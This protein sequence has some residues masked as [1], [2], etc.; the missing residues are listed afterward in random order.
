MDKFHIHY[1][2]SY[3]KKM[4]LCRQRLGKN[5][6]KDESVR[7]ELWSHS[8]TRSICITWRRI[9]NTNS[10]ASLQTYCVRNSGG[11]AQALGLNKSAR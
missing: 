10:P 5:E 8:V 3:I 9:R 7:M 6:Q 11:E 4:A 2:N 1:D